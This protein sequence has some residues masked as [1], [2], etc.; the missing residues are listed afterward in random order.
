[1]A[2]VSATI[3]SRIHNSRMEEN[4]RERERKKMYIYLQVHAWK[5]IYNLPDWFLLACMRLAYVM[6]ALDG[7]LINVLSNGAYLRNG[8]VWG[9]RR[10][11][12]KN[13]KLS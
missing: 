1:M 13:G 6:Y 3:E 7:R 9:R 4:G 5:A 12:E 11:R 8:K 10:E 2:A